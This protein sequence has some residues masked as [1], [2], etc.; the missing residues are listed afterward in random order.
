[1]K[2]N[3]LKKTKNDLL[4]PSGDIEKLRKYDIDVDNYKSMNELSF[5]IDYALNNLDLVSD[6][7]EELEDILRNIEERNYY[8]N[9]KK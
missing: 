2:D 9:I 4:I 3:F 8:Y 1:M 7:E 5:A 6:E